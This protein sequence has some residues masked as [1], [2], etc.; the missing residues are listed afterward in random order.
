MKILFADDDSTIRCFFLELVD[1]DD[2][3]D[4]AF[5]GF[6]AVECFRKELDKE[7]PYDAV[8]LD[9]MMPKMDGYK[10]LEEIRKYEKEKQFKSEK[11]STMIMLSAKSRMNDEKSTII[12]LYDAYLRMPVGPTEI[13]N[14]LDKIRSN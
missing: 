6:Q 10:A 12:E 7:K 4:I 5:D 3:V 1:K 8:F 14:L 9:I 11:K 2:T 13:I